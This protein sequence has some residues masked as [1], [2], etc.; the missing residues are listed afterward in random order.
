MRDVD[1]RPGP[2][3]RLL[4]G[5]FMLTFTAGWIDAVS[6]L[7]LGRVFV[8]N[9]TGNVVL[10]GFAL[11]GASGLSVATSLT[12]LVGF[13]AGAVASGRLAAHLQGRRRRWLATALVAETACV[14]VAAAIAVATRGTAGAAL[15]IVA[16]LAAAMGLQTGTA[17]RLAVPDLTTTVLTMT[18]AALAVDSRLSGGDN[19]RS[20]RR[21]TAVVAMLAG[22]LGG[23]LLVLRGGPAAAL[24]VAAGLVAL[25][26]AAVATG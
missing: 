1:K 8:A 14:G 22:A 7:G 4:A 26:A 23:G 6:F 20:L 16:V 21:I 11:A 15:A 24:A 13:L 17:R 3:S 19:E 10:L 9:M 25:A 12:A 5:M 2:S 18:L